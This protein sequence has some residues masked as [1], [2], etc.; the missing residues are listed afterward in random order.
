MA[1][2]ATLASLTLSGLVAVGLGSAALL[3]AWSGWLEL[4]RTELGLRSGGRRPGGRKEISDLR[5]R[6]RRLET[7]ASGG[8]V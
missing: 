6:V 7:I 5:E 1:D 2:P 8:E 3:K 4:R